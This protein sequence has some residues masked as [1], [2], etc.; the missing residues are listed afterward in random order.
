MNCPADSK[1]DAEGFRAIVGIILA[2]DDNRLF[3][4]R[5]VGMNAW[6]FP[7]GGIRPWENEEIAMYRELREETGL[8]PEH[9]R[10]IGS[11]REWLRYELPE[12]FIR[13]NSRPVCRGQKQRWFMLRLL[14][15]EDSVR[16]DLADSPEFDHWCWI[17]F[18]EPVNQVIEFKRKV[19][20]QVLTEFEQLLR[21]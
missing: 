15:D 11:S 3:W 14:V 5:R 2:N 9:V 13:R 1:I 18:W 16:L 10:L 19:Y 8:L 7:Q 6:Q 4:A 17:D 21:S 12:R 20:R